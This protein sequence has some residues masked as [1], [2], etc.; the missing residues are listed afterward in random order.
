MKTADVPD[1]SER[2]ARFLRWFFT[3]APDADI[4]PQP[5]SASQARSRIVAH[6]TPTRL[7]P[8]H[9]GPVRVSAKGKP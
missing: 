7:R 3:A 2:V 9:S 8:Q 1:L 5:F 6:R 4:A